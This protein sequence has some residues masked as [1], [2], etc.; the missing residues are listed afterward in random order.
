M[1]VGAIHGF[2][3]LGLNQAFWFGGLPFGI[4]LFWVEYFD[5]ERENKR[6]DELTSRLP[7]EVIYIDISTEEQFMLDNLSKR[8]SMTNE[9]YIR[10]IL[11]S[12]TKGCE[13]YE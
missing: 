8:E 2:T 9:K 1:E 5:S 12:I 13:Y 4:F 11:K 10:Y 7:N 3:F 6:V